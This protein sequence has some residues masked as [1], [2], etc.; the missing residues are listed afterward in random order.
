MRSEEV[1]C[2]CLRGGR[3]PG[4]W[5]AKDEQL[6]MREDC[7]QVRFVLPEHAQVSRLAL[8]G[9]LGPVLSGDKA[10]RAQKRWHGRGQA[11]PILLKI[12]V[13]RHRSE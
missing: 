13:E 8:A 3:F 9:S 1:L 12:I 5:L 4:A 10:A 2:H 7:R 6:G 11:L